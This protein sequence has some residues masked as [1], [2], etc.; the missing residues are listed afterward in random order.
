MS[1]SWKTRF[2]GARGN[3]SIVREVRQCHWPHNNGKLPHA[4]PGLADFDDS[5]DS[6]FVSG[7]PEKATAVCLR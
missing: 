1:G 4:L 2:K 5:M 7:R 3:A 6:R